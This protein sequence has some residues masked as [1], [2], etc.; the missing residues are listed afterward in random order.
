MRHSFLSY[1]KD[2]HLATQSFH[3]KIGLSKYSSSCDFLIDF[4]EAKIIPTR[5]RCKYWEGP[6]VIDVT[7]FREL[8]TLMRNGN[9]KFSPFVFFRIN[10]DFP[11]KTFNGFFNDIKSKPGTLRPACSAVKHFEYV[12]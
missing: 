7:I 6:S 12:A 11:I 8:N 9:D 5:L 2:D 3:E 1:G 4:A 10:I